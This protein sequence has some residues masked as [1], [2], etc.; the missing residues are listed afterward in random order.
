MTSRHE[1][2]IFNILRGEPLLEELEGTTWDKERTKLQNMQIYHL[3]NGFIH[4]SKLKW[5][6]EKENSKRIYQGP[7]KN[8]NIIFNVGTA[9]IFYGDAIALLT[10][11]EIPQI[12]EPLL[13]GARGDDLKISS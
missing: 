6:L 12:G 9:V 3:R 2:I 8:K 11:R 13:R 1:N 10:T 4:C 5:D 7:S